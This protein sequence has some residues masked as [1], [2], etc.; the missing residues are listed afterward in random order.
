M[1]LLQ[2]V[3]DLSN[4]Y[5]HV[6]PCQVKMSLKLCLRRKCLVY[7]YVHNRHEINVIEKN[8]K[9]LYYPKYYRG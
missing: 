4:L 8:K 5:Y 1:I 7:L 3:E 6:L 9:H 2:I